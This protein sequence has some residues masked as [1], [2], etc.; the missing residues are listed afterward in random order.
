M[1]RKFAYL[2]AFM[3]T[4]SAAASY[5]QDNTLTAKEKAD[6]WELL[7]DGKDFNG[8]STPGDVP[9]E[10]RWK[11][12]NGTLFLS[13]KPGVKGHADL[14]SAKEYTN[15]DL[16]VDFKLTEGANSGI[17]YFFTKYDEG[18]WLG[19][20]F[21]LIDNDRHPDA[22]LGR[23]GDRQLSALYDMLPVT[24]KVPVKVGEWNHIR[25]V[26]Q[27]TKVTHYVNGKEVLKY[28]R[29]SDEFEKA[30]QLSKFIDAK[31]AFGSVNKGHIMIQDHNDVVYF[32][33]VKIKAL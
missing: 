22:K 1:K 19:P 11:I 31:P 2:A 6:G 18:G 27:G 24:K 13:P 25:V 16:Q 4:C 30:R 29:A 32:K 20:E 5:A 7:F 17:K 21:Q 12:E 9:V 14:I 10:G 26:A 15:F 33:N 23:D 3:L 28:D 8:L